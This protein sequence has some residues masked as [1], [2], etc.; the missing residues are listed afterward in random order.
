MNRIRKHGNIYQVLITPYQSFTVGLEIMR[1]SFNMDDEYLMNYKV[2]NFDTLGEAQCEAFNHVDID[3]DSLVLLHNNAYVDIRSIIRK[4]L[5][6][7]KMTVEFEP[8]IT[9]SLTLKNNIFD[10]VIKYGDRFRLSY[11]MNDIISYNIINPW[12]KNVEAIANNL[13]ENR[14]LRI[15][16]KIKTYGITTLIGTTDLSTTYEIVIWPT[17]L[18]Q[19]AKWVHDNDITDPDIKQGTLKKTLAVQK[20]VDGNIIFR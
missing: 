13:I 1:G 3:W 10:R 9:D 16:K 7:S 5:G 8:R 19:W 17:L 11:Q 6:H 15:F 14:D 12:S 2:L 18:Y 20:N 4:S